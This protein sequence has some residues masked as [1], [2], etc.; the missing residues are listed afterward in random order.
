MVTQTNE[1]FDTILTH[2]DPQVAE[3][4]RLVRALIYEVLTQVVEV[5]WVQQKTIG[6]GTGPKKMS[7]HFSYIAPQK[8]HVNLGFYYGAEL[9]DPEG[10]LEG[11]G[12]LLRHIKIRSREDLQ[13][14]A[15]RTMLELAT[16]HRVPPP[17]DL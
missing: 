4:S 13:K 8:K 5:P 15:V 17:K 6:Y 10:M 11:T 14:P 9:P 1:E 7:E 3:L 2:F 12:K 16:R